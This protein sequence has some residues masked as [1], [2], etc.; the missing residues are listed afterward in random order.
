MCATYTMQVKRE[1]IR[2]FD[3]VSNATTVSLVIGSDKRR[4]C[5]QHMYMRRWRFL[6]ALH[7]KTF[8]LDDEYLGDPNEQT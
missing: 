5:L 2:Q 6:G 7:C 1:R 8:I 4:Y 3:E